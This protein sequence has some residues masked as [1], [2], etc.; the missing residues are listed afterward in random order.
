MYDTPKLTFNV[1]K[2]EDKNYADGLQFDPAERQRFGEWL[3]GLIA[4]DEGSMR[5]W[6]NRAKA[7]IKRLEEDRDATPEDTTASDGTPGNNVGSDV[8]LGAV[9]QFHARFVDS[10]LSEPDFVKAAVEGAEKLAEWVSMQLRVVDT[11]WASETDRMAPHVALTGMGWRK[12]WVDRRRGLFESCF[13]PVTDVIINASAP[14]VERAPRITHCMEKYPHEIYPLVKRKDW[15]DYTEREKESDDDPHAPVGFLECHTWL[16]MDKDG[17]DEPWTVTIHEA[18]KEVVALYPRWSASGVIESSNEDGKRQRRGN[19]SYTFRAH[20]HFSAYTLLPSISGR[21]HGRGY[22]WLLRRLEA[23]AD[24]LLQGAVD[25]VKAGAEDGGIVGDMGGGMPT[26][27]MLKKDRLTSVPVDGQGLAANTVMF[28]AKQLPPSVPQMVDALVG[29]GD[30]LAG[31]TAALSGSDTPANMPAT[32]AVAIVQQGARVHSALHRRQW[33][34]MTLEIRNF[35]DLAK[36]ME[37]LP[38]ELMGVP[39]EGLVCTADQQLSTEMGRNM[40]ASYY[41]S[42][43]TDPYTN[44]VEVRIRTHK[45]MRVPNPEKLMQQP[46]PQQGRPADE[47]DKLKHAIDMLK[48]QQTGMTASAGALKNVVDAIVAIGGLMGIGVQPTAAAQQVGPSVAAAEA[49]GMQQSPAAPPAAD[50]G[51]DDGGLDGSAGAGMAGAPGD[52]G[53]AGLDAAGFQP[54][55]SPMGGGLAGPDGA[56]PSQTAADLAGAP[57]G[58]VT[59]AENRLGK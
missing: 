25:I 37:M 44:P 29:Y 5:Q 24:G 12:R 17:Y 16:D 14:S 30:K 11:G 43:A 59:A 48:T 19:R 10:F 47:K 18:S 38:Q 28:P 33:E 23:S 35:V 20:Q 57:Q 40:M 55:G 3:C 53:S 27:I 45:L 39:T 42:I 2:P 9:M 58:A 22:G 52:A 56:G 1:L 13:L 34:C 15:C 32:T 36:Q 4:V 50:G 46:P 41:A 6:L 8:V 31:T 54:A 49:G 26:S 51:M 7:D 21:F